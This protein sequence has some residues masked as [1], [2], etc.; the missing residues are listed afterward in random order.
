MAVG[1]A[2]KEEWTESQGSHPSG[3]CSFDSQHSPLSLLF[4]ERLSTG[5]ESPGGVSWP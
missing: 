2:K 3:F 5:S 1:Q 4:V